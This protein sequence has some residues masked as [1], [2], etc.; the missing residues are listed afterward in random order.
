MRLFLNEFPATFFHMP[1]FHFNS[2]SSLSFAP[3]KLGAFARCLFTGTSLNIAF[4]WCR[5]TNL[6]TV[7]ER[8]RA[9]AL[10]IVIGHR[11]RVLTLDR[12]SFIE[13]E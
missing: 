9:L 2:S 3:F 5:G 10:E 1:R 7:P 11:A 6:G 8:A 4:C 12:T 13:L